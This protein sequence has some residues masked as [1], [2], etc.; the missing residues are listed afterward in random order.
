MQTAGTVKQNGCRNVI[1][2][3]TADRQEKASRYELTV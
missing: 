1:S 3:F 2:L